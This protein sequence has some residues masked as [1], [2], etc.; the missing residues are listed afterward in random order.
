MMKRTA[1]VTAFLLLTACLAWPQGA[2]HLTGVEP[3]TAKVGQSVTATGENLAKGTVVAIFLSDA[4]NDYKVQVLEQTAEK[5]VFKVGQVKPAS[6][7]VSLQ[8]RNEIFIQPV[9]L[10]VE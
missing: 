9:R 8:V 3:T 7:N 10:T 6:Y 2:P 1:C 5:I 4:N